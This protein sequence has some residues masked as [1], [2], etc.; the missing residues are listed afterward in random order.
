MILPWARRD[1]ADPACHAW[2]EHALAP[3][4]RFELTTVTRMSASAV[5]AELAT[6][7][8]LFIGGGNTY[9]LLERL[10]N[11]GTDELIAE[12]VR[13]GLPCYGGSA[14][15]IVFGRDIG[16]CA[17]IDQN[18]SALE[19]L[20]GLD[21]CAGRSL[22]CHYEPAHRAHVETFRAEHGT[23]VFCLP[24]N[25]GLRIA[26]RNAFALGAAEV[27]IHTGSEVRRVPRWSE[28]DRALGE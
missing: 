16:T 3:F 2:V 12:R 17:H 28:A 22:F 20:S 18:E 11:T 4:G 5:R 1:P 25:A 27:T 23:D 19:D 21:L 6:T 26:D 7:A 15:A 10:R 9:R 8:G 24:E 14:G 13:A